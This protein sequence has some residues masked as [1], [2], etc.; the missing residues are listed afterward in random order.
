MS[1]TWTKKGASTYCITMEG[2]T[3]AKCYTDT[4]DG[5]TWHSTNDADPK[6]VVTII[7]TS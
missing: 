7:R 1:G 6:D 4:M 3:A 5:T 2:E